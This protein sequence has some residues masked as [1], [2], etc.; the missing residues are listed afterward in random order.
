[1]TDLGPNKANRH[2][3]VYTANSGLKF[4]YKIMVLLCLKNKVIKWSMY[5]DLNYQLRL[6]VGILYCKLYNRLDS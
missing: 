3:S 6:K 1:M 5:K 4:S 2:S